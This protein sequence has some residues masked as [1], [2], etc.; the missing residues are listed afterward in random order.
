MSRAAFGHVA[1]AARRRSA[2]DGEAGGYSADCPACLRGVAHTDRQH[3]AAVERALRCSEDCPRCDGDGE[4]PGAPVELDGGRWLCS[5][6]GG[7]G[8]GAVAR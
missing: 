6:C 5:E 3:H 8:R 7:T 1:D 4:E 2:D